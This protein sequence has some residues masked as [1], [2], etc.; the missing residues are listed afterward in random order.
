MSTDTQQFDT[1]TLFGHPTGLYM[2]F[3]AEMWERFSYYGMR[4][5][6]VFYMIKGF[7]GYNDDEAYAVYGAYTALVYATPFI[8]G[9]LADR[10][11]GARRAVVLGGLLM[12]AGHL[13]MTIETEVMFFL[14]LALLICGNGFFKPNISTIVG[15]L[16]PK[17]SVK[18]DT[19]F[20]LFYMGI[21]LGAAMSPVI[22]GYVGENYGWHYGFGLATFGMLV[23][24]AVFVAPTRLTQMLILFGAVGTSVSMLFFQDTMLQ[25]A[26]R[27]CLAVALGIAG[28]IAYVAL[29]RGGLPE[30]VGQ[31]PSD[32]RLSDPAFPNLREHCVVYYLAIIAATLVLQHLTPPSTMEAWMI[33]GIAGAAILLPWTS[34]RSAVF[35]GVAGAIPT[36]VLMVHRSELAG[37]MLFGFGFIAFGSLIREAIRST[38]VE[39]ERMYVVLVLMSFSMLFWAFFEQAGSSVNN[40]TD[41]NVDRV[42]ED[43]DKTITEAQ[44][45][46]TIEFRVRPNPDD[47]EIAKL[48]LLSQEQLGFACDDELLERVAR[49]QKRKRAEREQEKDVKGQDGEVDAKLLQAI[50]ALLEEKKDESKE[51]SD[52]IAVSVAVSPANVQEDGETNLTYTFT[53]TGD[54]SEPLKVRFK[55]AGT[56]K[57]VEIKEKKEKEE[58][59]KEWW[60][61]SW[62]WLTEGRE[63]EHEETDYQVKGTDS[64]KGTSGLVTIPAGAASATV[65]VDPTPNEKVEKD[66]TVIV[67]V[68]SA[69][70]YVLGDEAEAT[71]TI[72][73]DDKIFTMT[74]LSVLRSEASRDEATR[75]DLVVSWTITEKHDG[76]A[77]ADAEIPATEFQAANPLFIIV[78]GLLFSGLWGVMNRLGMEPSTPVKFAMGLFQ[79]GLAFGAFWYGA[80]VADER[81]MVAMSWLLF[82]YLLQT[83][84]ELCLSPVGLS[85]VT[86]LSPGRIVS[87]AM[88][89][90]FLATA[91]SNFLAG[92]IASFTGVSHGGGGEQVIPPPAETVNIYGDVF[93]TIALCAIASSVVCLLLAP[94]L[95]RWM[96]SEVDD[97]GELLPTED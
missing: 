13:L 63:D 7:L 86:K 59:T 10:L 16:Y 94:T 84:G 82:G 23:G 83:T 9:V 87:T 5:L 27:V 18:K 69:A 2:L 50:N 22:C 21:N 30:K 95:T 31:A 65:I 43:T 74:H 78:F 32:K 97:S 37:V 53:R 80:Q 91:F 40:F 14:A 34:A 42:L 70:D 54:T 24:I 17:G 20:T 79:L 68:A 88:G 15:E 46:S 67:S 1:P 6:L 89:A 58:E 76:M 36:I 96:H 90:W 44:F 26:I 35:V 8:G 19:G 75:E 11:L 25:L 85:M 61:E 48:P 52:E 29:D 39:R 41:R 33:A 64:F 47:E 12:A 81:G 56:A 66:E 28:V 77:I 92:I 4:A 60:Q 93:G 45:G 51:D 62:E 49:I 57:F 72:D 73:N 3:F 55:T 38:K 71:G